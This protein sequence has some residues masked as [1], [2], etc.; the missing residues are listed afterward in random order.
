MADTNKRTVRILTAIF[1]TAEGMAKATGIAPGAA[2][3]L[4]ETGE[5]RLKEFRAIKETLGLKDE[6]LFFPA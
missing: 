5:L 1:E 4:M 2:A 6:R 3:E